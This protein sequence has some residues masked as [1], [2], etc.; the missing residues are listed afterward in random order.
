EAP[1]AD[2]PRPAQRRRTLA[3]VIAGG[4]L[5][6]GL[7]V[8][9]GAL[10]LG[11]VLSGAPASP[12]DSALPRV[13]DVTGRAGDGTIVFSWADP[14]LRDSDS[15]VVSLR[16][17]ESSIQRGTQFT[18]QTDTAPSAART[19]VCVTVSVNRDGRTGAASTEKC[20]DPATGAQ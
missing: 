16:S 17:G 4:L 12:G 5:V 15:Y 7:G 10:L 18:V 14:G 13:S 2:R 19:P 9:A 11:P 8:V 3:A 20:V 6:V 1:R